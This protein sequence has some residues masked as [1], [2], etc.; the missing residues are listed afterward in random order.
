MRG[1]PKA[2]ALELA[3]DRVRVC[4]VHP[5]AIRTPV[6]AGCGDAYTAG[7]PIPRFGKPEEVAR[8]VLFIV[9]DATFSTGCEFI[10]DGG[11]PAGAPAVLTPD[12]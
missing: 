5:G 12:V 3:P 9:T 4:S 7:Q 8:M 2:A 11:I 6:T 10:A 1:L